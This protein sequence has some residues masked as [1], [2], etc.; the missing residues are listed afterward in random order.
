L[1]YWTTG[2]ATPGLIRGWTLTM[3][4]DAELVY[5][6]ENSMEP[7]YIKIG[8]VMYSLQVTTYRNLASA[9]DTILIMTSS[10]TLSGHTTGAGFSF[11]GVTDLGSYNYT[12]ETAS[13]DENSNTLV[14]T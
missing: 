3:T 4:Q 13:P 6:N 2:S 1:G 8:L 7:D 10:F 14:I 12:F 5:K 11:G 9:L